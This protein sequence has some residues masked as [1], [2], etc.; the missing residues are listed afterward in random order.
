MVI[1]IALLAFGCSAITCAIV[2]AWA[3]ETERYRL[4]AV[5]EAAAAFFGFASGIFLVLLLITVNA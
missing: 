1:N 3:Y 5:Y 2:S 4:A